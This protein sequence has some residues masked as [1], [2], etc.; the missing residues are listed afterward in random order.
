VKKASGITAA[1]RSP[2]INA[3]EVKK[4]IFYVKPVLST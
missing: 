4:I 3:E 2:E 1:K